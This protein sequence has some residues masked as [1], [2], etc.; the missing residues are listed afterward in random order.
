MRKAGIRE[1]RQ[2]LTSLLEDVRKGRE[3]L[4]TDRGRPVAR[5]VPVR[6]QRPFPDLRAVRLA[7]KAGRP[8]VSQ[9]VIDDREDRV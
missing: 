4:L 7:A 9:A 5:L 1:A 2:D 8:N 6:P 3:V